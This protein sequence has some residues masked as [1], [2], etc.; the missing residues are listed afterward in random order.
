MV[1]NKGRSVMKAGVLQMR[2][3]R[4]LWKIHVRAGH[5]I[6]CGRVAIVAL[7]GKINAESRHG[8]HLSVFY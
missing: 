6:A 2:M 4:R 5:F 3:L 7:H 1:T 8:A